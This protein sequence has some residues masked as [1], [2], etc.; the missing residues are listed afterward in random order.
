VTPRKFRSEPEE[1]TSEPDSDAVFQGLQ[2][3]YSRF[4]LNESL[5]MKLSKE[6]RK[7]LEKIIFFLYMAFCRTYYQHET[8]SM[9]GSFELYPMQFFAL[10]NLHIMPDLRFPVQ[11]FFR[12]KDW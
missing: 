10:Y 9:E 6:S 7:K 11:N 4:P 3:A 12:S 5:F 2:A 1:D 8:F